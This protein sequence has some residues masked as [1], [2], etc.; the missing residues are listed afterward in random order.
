MKEIP[1]R[2]PWGEDGELPAD[3][4]VII[5]LSYHWKE[6]FPTSMEIMGGVV[7]RWDLRNGGGGPMNLAP[8]RY[9]LDWEVQ[10][11]DDS[12]KGCYGLP[13]EEVDAW[14]PVD[15]LPEGF[16]PKFL[17]IARVEK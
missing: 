4:Q 8:G 12:G 9:Q 13:G 11:S 5:A 3:G 7:E 6:V 10:T 14:C 15:E 2:N 17:N 16:F 1:W